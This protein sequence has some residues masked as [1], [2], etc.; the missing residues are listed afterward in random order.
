M[1]FPT[2]KSVR[3]TRAVKSGAFPVYIRV[4]YM[5]K[6]RFF[7][8]GIKVLA[9]DWDEAACRIKKSG[10]R[11]REDNDLLRTMEQRV[12][13]C[14]M[15]IRRE[16]IA[17]SFGR[18]EAAISGGSDTPVMQ[19]RISELAKTV[20]A[21]Y[22]QDGREGTAGTYTM[23]ASV[24][25]G[26]GTYKVGDM[27]V[28]WLEGFER[29]LRR[30]RGNADGGVHHTMR[31]L[32]ATCNWAIKYRGARKDWYPFDGYALRKPGR[33][34][35][36]R[37]LS[38]EDFRKIEG[39]DPGERDRL[40]HDLFCLSFYLW[41]ANMADMA[42][43][44]EKSLLNGRVEYVREKTKR[45][46]RRLYS[47]PLTEKVSA[48]FERWKGR[49]KPG[50]LLPI[51]QEGRADRACVKSASDRAGLALKR[52][53]EKAGVSSARIT[54][55]SARHTFATALAAKGAG[56]TVIR[57]MLGHEDLRTTEGYVRKHSLGEMDAAARE[58]G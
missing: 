57:D 36:S 24:L 53:A 54:M 7:P 50:Y 17:F 32:R 26:F 33:D 10:P 35:G 14:L 45:T 11:W 52:I 23:L 58:L 13:D 37:A 47:V 8:T 18:I 34:S 22:A 4:T 9:T 43:L 12:S 20:A 48:I 29:Y 5:G 19:M 49:C 21:K 16:G 15:A 6:H 55:Y 46:S 41:G 3:H 56:L 1:A 44:T 25:D 31:T 51:M 42:R 30:V 2:F 28:E 27:S 40:S 38:M 39:C